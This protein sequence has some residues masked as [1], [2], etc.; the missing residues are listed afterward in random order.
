[1]FG[2]EP[3]KGQSEEIHL[4]FISLSNWCHILFVAHY[5]S[6]V[7]QNDI[8]EGGTEG[9]TTNIFRTFVQFQCHCQH[10]SPSNVA[11]G[12]T[13]RFATD[14]LR[15]FVSFSLL[16][17]SAPLSLLASCSMFSKLLAD[18][19]IDDNRWL[20]YETF[21]QCCANLVVDQV[22]LADSRSTLRTSHLQCYQ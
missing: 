16:Q 13:D 15:S 8:A 1:M 5:V 21:F 2:R 20:N 12:K 17:I 11:Q 18:K 6:N 7:V 14:S 9:V 22:T 19:E 4:S 10:Q 3:F